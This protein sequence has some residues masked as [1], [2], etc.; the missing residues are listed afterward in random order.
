MKRLKFYCVFKSDIKTIENLF[1][2]KFIYL[3]FLLI[4]YFIFYFNIS[5]VNFLLY[6]YVNIFLFLDVT[7][8]SY[9]IYPRLSDSRIHVRFNVA[10]P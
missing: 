7:Y 5:S 8:S 2:T 10:Y 4:I 3:F 1:Y 6:N 9:G